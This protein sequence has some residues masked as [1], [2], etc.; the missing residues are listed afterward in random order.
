M[1]KI[2]LV[3]IWTLFSC[4]SV[5]R[6]KKVQ[7]EEGPV[8]IKL[9][10]ALAKVVMVS[11]SREF[12]A[13]LNTARWLTSRTQLLL[14]P[15]LCGW[16]WGGRRGAAARMQIHQ[17]GGQGGSR[18]LE[19]RRSGPWGPNRQTGDLVPAWQ[20]ILNLIMRS[21][22]FGDTYFWLSS[23]SPV[24]KPFDRHSAIIISYTALITT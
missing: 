6:S 24:F 22:T 4:Q 11:W 2:A 17:G 5:Y 3:L 10:G 23:V 9:S 7:L 15:F 18:R 8:G 12:K 20:F 1:A 16:H 19:P 21:N 14:A 13:T